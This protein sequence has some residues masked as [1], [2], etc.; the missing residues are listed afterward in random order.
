[1][2]AWAIMSMMGL[3]PDCPG[4]PYYTLTTPVFN[5]VTL[6][7]DPKYYPAGDITISTDRTSPSQLYIK[8]MTLGGKPLGSY[9]ISHKQLTEGRTLHMTLK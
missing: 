5:K 6:H 3:Y 1:M 9:R 2:S 8:G 7:L 4:E